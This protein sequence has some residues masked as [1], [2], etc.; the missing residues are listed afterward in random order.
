MSEVAGKIELSESANAQT[1]ADFIGELRYVVRQPGEPRRASYPPSA[2]LT[3]RERE[4][5]QHSAQA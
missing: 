1:L 2:F 5:L 3:T 4:S